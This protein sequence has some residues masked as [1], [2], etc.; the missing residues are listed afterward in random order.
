MES[1]NFSPALVRILLVDDF[2]PFRRFVRSLIQLRSEWQI[3]GEAFDGLQAVQ[4]AEEL[5]P[6]LVL[7]DI[8]LPKL[9]GIEAARQI[10]VLSP[11]CKILFVSQ[12]S[13]SDML[14]AAL[15]AGASG[16]VVKVHA[17]IELVAAIE[18]VLQGNQLF[19]QG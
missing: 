3:V 2:E 1:P 18:A 13:T 15:S 10:R 12:Q 9:S 11:K 8:G 5:Q 6:D 4:T 19:S 17:G 7:L 14:P 16:Y